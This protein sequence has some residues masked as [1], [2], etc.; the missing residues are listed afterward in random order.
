MKFD[1]I[2]Y[3][4]PPVQNLQ[5]VPAYDEAEDGVSMCPPKFCLNQPTGTAGNTIQR[6]AIGEAKSE[7]SATEP[8]EKDKTP[9]VRP[10]RAISFKDFKH[11]MNIYFGVK[12]IH[13]STQDEQEK[14][15]VKFAGPLQNEWNNW[16]AEQGPK[17]SIAGWT[18][19][20]PGDTSEDY[21]SII[22]A[23]ED[24]AGNFPAV[25]T[26]IFLEKEYELV[27]KDLSA[28]DKT[29]DKSEE[30]PF[31][32]QAHNSVGASYSDGTIYI[33]GAFDSDT[34]NQ[35]TKRSK[36]KDI[37]AARTGTKAENIR[38][39]IVHELSHGVAEAAMN[40]D[41]DM[42]TKYKAAAGWIN[43]GNGDVLYDI[44]KNEVGEALTQGAIPDSEYKISPGMWNN[45]TIVE[46]PMS[47]YAVQGGPTEDFA[48]SLT[49]F[50]I[51][52]GVLKDRSPARYTFIKNG[53]P[54]WKNGLGDKGK[55]K[56]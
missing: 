34:T 19:W 15:A 54:E 33:H 32:F 55:A 49:A 43:D 38:Y 48:E 45:S 22:N 5:D 36:D 21:T 18:R 2:P 25:H 7:K 41:K 12:D 26:I 13:I 50:I 31:E 9:R 14:I 24:M 6:Q 20:F 37:S 3:R 29:S 35:A 56:P 8:S 40:K 53:M 39:N 44:G 23:M 30:A 27:K 28:K 17:P 4:N 51:T 16:P 42:F 46:Q 52:P 10:S 1:F 47:K 11:Y